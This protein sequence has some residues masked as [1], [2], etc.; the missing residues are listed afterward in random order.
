[1]AAARA[2]NGSGAINSTQAVALWA[3]LDPA[4]FVEPLRADVC[5]SDARAAAEHCVG[6]TV[7]SGD[8]VC[9]PRR[10]NKTAALPPATRANR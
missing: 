10:R 2:A 7:V 3:T 8:C 4:L 5:G 9:Y 6:I 1:M